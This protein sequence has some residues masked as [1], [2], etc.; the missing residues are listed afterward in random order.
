MKILT[1]IDTRFI[2]AADP[3]LTV[4]ETFDHIAKACEEFLPSNMRIRKIKALK[5]DDYYLRT[6]DNIGDVVDDLDEVYC[7][8]ELHGKKK[9]ATHENK[10]TKTH[11]QEQGETK[12]KTHSKAEDNKS[13]ND[14]AKETIAEHAK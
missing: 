4:H 14:K 1:S 6:S 2:L 3:K 7:E 8:V 13:S 10:N 12:N 9:E 5:K 11:K